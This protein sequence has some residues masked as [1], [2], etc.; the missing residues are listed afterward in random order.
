MRAG[1]LVEEQ[2]APYLDFEP[3]GGLS[4]LASRAAS[5]RIAVGP[6][7]GRRTMRLRTAPIEPDPPTGPLTAMRE[8]F[9]LNAAVACQPHQRRKLERLCQYMA[10][11]PHTRMSWMQRLRRVFDIDLSVCPRC[12]SPTRVIAVLTDPAVISAILKHIDNRAPRA[13]P[14]TSANVS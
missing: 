6:L 4:E 11:T 2:G 7:A 3:E 12:S 13:P 14:T 9:S 5:Y 10:R 8:G 1:V